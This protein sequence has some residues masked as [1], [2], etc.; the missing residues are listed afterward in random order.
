MCIPSVPP[1]PS[2]DGSLRPDPRR[3]GYTSSKDGNQMNLGDG[4]ARSRF[5]FTVIGK[6]LILNARGVLIG[7][8][9][10]MSNTNVE[11]NTINFS[12]S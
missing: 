6:A 2:Q 5:Q 8:A 4:H 9:S 10:A 7:Q 12:F 3:Y 11:K 1:P